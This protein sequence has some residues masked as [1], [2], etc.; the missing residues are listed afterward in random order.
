MNGASF[1]PNTGI[2]PGGIATIRG[3]GILP[4]VQGVVSAANSDGQLPTTFSGVTITFNGT[5]APIYYVDHTNGVDQ[6]SVQV[7]FEVQPGPCRALQISVAT[8]APVTVMVPVKP[9]APGVFTSSYGGKTYA[10]AVR[11]DGS[12]GEPHQSGAK[13]RKYST[14]CHR[15]GS[16]HSNHSN[17][18]C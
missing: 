11:P 9:L 15:P 1:D 6:I 18:R 17:R 12:P 13:R 3:T 8:E 7:P 2:S 16:G 4:G 14:L 10:V 5:P